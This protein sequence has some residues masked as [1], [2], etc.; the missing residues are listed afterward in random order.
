MPTLRVNID[1]GSMEKCMRLLLR[2]V[3]LKDILLFFLQCSVFRCAQ[4]NYKNIFNIF[5]IPIFEK[6]LRRYKHFSSSN[7][8]FIIIISV[9]ILNLTIF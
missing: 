1:D 6:I 2:N 8:S 5:N 9:Y 4:E 3:N 7:T